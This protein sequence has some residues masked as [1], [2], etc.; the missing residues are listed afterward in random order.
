MLIKRNTLYLFIQLIV[1]V[2]IAII[3]FSFVVEHYNNEVSDFLTADSLLYRERAILFSTNNINLFDFMLDYG[4]N[5]SGISALGS[6]AYFDGTFNDWFIIV[7]NTLFLV[8]G[9]IFLKRLISYSTIKQNN[10]SIFILLLFLYI[11]FSLIQLN[12]EL[13]GFTFI[14]LVMYTFYKRNFL[15]LFLIG[16]LFGMFRMQYFAIALILILY[17][18]P[19]LIILIALIHI[20]LILFIPPYI[21]AWYIAVGG[22]VGS[23]EL[24]HKLEEWSYIPVVGMLVFYFRIILS[25]TVG[26][27]API[28]ILNNYELLVGYI[29]YTSIFILSVLALIYLYQRYKIN[30][31][32]L[33]MPRI[34]YTNNYVLVVFLAISSIPPFLQPRYYLPLVLLFIVNHICFQQIWRVR[35]EQKKNISCN[36]CI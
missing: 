34:Y 28:D 7:L 15:F 4:W 22:N 26:L 25:F 13:I 32:K 35:N 6:L 29:Y 9:Y 14:I 18:K 19:K 3:M 30:K 10:Y 12:K 16:L 36:P 2:L 20:G 17:R 24:M 33:Q 31:L 1:Q 27:K 11:P 8:F 5:Y 23:Y 21:E